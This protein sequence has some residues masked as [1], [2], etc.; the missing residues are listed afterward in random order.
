MKRKILITIPVFIFAILLTGF[1]ISEKNSYVDSSV[2]NPR[3]DS[4]SDITVYSPM[5][6]SNNDMYSINGEN[7]YLRLQMIKGKYYEEW[8]PGPYMGTIWEGDFIIELIDD[9]GE[10]IS[11]IDLRQEYNENLIFTSPFQIQFD[12]LV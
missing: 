12:V 3:N 6:I 10:S 2:D 11:K 7:Q 8:T 9:S 4:F 1:L 5:T